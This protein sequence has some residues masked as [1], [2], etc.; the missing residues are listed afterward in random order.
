VSVFSENLI[1]CVGLHKRQVVPGVFHDHLRMMPFPRA[2]GRQ[3]IW[4][5]APRSVYF[6]LAEIQPRC[7]P[8]LSVHHQA[9]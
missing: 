4:P 3:V 2:E 9:R 5:Q 8:S 1:E 6:E 7:Q